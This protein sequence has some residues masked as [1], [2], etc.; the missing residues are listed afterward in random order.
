[1]IVE[2]QRDEGRRLTP[3]YGRVQVLLD[4]AT[5]TGQ[6]KL[7]FD[8]CLLQDGSVTDPRQFQ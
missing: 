7:D 6:I 4:V 5:N 2:Q 8:T 1:M 3:R